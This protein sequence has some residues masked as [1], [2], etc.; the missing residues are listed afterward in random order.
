MGTV[1]TL[2]GVLNQ[3][4]WFRYDV[5][6]DVISLRLVSQHMADTYSEETDDGFILIKDVVFRSM[7]ERTLSLLA[8]FK[9]SIDC[10]LFS[11]PK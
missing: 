11:H 3:V 2:E 1:D 6:N 7:I 9:Q 5:G 8:Y 10:G 4:L